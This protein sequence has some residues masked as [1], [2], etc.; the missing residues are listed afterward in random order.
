MPKDKKNKLI[1]LAEAKGND[2][3]L[4][5]FDMIEELFEEIKDKSELEELAGVVEEIRNIAQEKPKSD[6]E[7]IERVSLKITAKLGLLEKGDKGDKG[8]RGEKGEQGLNG[9]DGKNGVDGIDGINGKDGKDG[10]NGIDGKDGKGLDEKEIEKLKKEI[11]DKIEDLEKRTKTAFSNQGRVQTPRY[12]YKPMLD[13]FTDNTDG[14]T[15]TF[16][17]SKAPKETETMEVSGTDFPIILDPTVDFTVSGRTLTLTDAVP[18]PTTGATL[19]C[20]Y[21]V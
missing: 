1:K 17:L 12:T 6:E 4:L 9:K 15:K 5:L 2:A 8:D 20:K 18:A 21:Y 13:R 7:L 19:I 16:T 11:E 10:K 14:A 3:D